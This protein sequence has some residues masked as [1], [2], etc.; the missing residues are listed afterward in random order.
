MAHQTTTDQVTTERATTQQNPAGPP[1]G[2][3]GGDQLLRIRPWWDPELAIAGFDARGAYCERFWLPIIGPASLLL[4]RLA[5]ETCKAHPTG[6]NLERAEVARSLGLGRSSGPN[7]PLANA[8]KRLEYFSLARQR[9][10]A[11]EVRTHLPAVPNPLLRRVPKHLRDNHATWLLRHSPDPSG[12]PDSS[13][14]ESP[15]VAPQVLNSSTRVRTP[16]PVPPL[17]LTSATSEA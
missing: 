7:G 3:A 13:P 4:L 9:N 12:S 10:D 5:A 15:S 17:G 14:A 16:K 1:R 8:T 6:V 11:L 2:D